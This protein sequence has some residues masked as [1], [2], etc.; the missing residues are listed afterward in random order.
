MSSRNWQSK[1]VDSSSSEMLLQVISA[2]S[3]GGNIH[4]GYTPKMVQSH[5]GMGASRRN[6]RN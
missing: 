1:S 2:S 6:G 5:G 3:L 4:K